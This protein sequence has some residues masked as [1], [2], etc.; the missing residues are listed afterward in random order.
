MMSAADTTTTLASGRSRSPYARRVSPSCRPAC[1]ASRDTCLGASA[2]TSAADCADMRH[3]LR[4]L[5]AAFVTRL[6][7]EVGPDRV[8]RD[9]FETGVD[10]GRSDQPARHLPYEHLHD[11][12]EALQ[13]GLLVDHEIKE[14]VA[15]RF[16]RFRQ[17]II[18]ACM[19]PLLR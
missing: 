19:H 2:G 7:I 13:I 6:G 3:D 12:I 4:F 17:Q 11:R 14:A 15:H 18:T 5:C 10:V 8:L 16:E 1:A 9:E